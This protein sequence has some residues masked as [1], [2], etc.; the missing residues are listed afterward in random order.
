GPAVAPESDVFKSQS[1]RGQLAKILIC[2]R[3]KVIANFLAKKGDKQSAQVTASQC[4]A[5]M[6]GH[7]QQN[8]SR[9]VIADPR[10]QLYLRRD[11]K[12]VVWRAGSSRPFMDVSRKLSSRYRG[13]E[14]T[15]R[16]AG[17]CKFPQGQK[18]NRIGCCWRSVL[19]RAGPNTFELRSYQL[20]PGAMIEWNQRRKTYRRQHAW[21]RLVCYMVTFIQEVESRIMILPKTLQL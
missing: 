14:E 7:I 12:H 4:Y 5:R 18:R 20:Q 13:G 16:K 10:R 21:E 2:Q 6:P 11:V 3:G 8:L 17:I 9:S 19:E 15:Q 1:S